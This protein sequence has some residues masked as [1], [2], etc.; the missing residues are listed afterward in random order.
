MD[1]IVQQSRVELFFVDWEKPRAKVFD[2]ESATSHDAPVSVWRTILVANEWNELQTLRRTS[3]ECTIIAL[4][5]LLVGC[6]LEYLA[7]PQ[8]S[9][10]NLS[11]GHVNTILRF[12]NT[13]F[14]WLVLSYGQLAY[15]VLIHERYIT[16]PKARQFIDL[17]TMAKVSVVILDERYHGYYLHC[18]SPYPFA[19]GS[20]VEIADQLK[21]E[22]AGLMSGRGLPGAPTDVQVFEMYITLNWRKN[23]DRMYAHLVS[24]QSTKHKLES[25]RLGSTSSRSSSRKAPPGKLVKASRKLNTFLKSFVE[26]HDDEF[27]WKYY[28]AQGWL[29]E[30]LQIP[31]EMGSKRTSYLIP[32]RLGVHTRASKRL[33]LMIY[34]HMS[35]YAIQ[36]CQSALPWNRT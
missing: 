12:F 26:N 5:F 25:G 36:F 9:S 1:K 18:R 19:D 32:G 10:T 15:R 33:E 16:E 34:S 27:R 8:P 14:W 6:K 2:S 24:K 23:Y 4:A 29:S 35:R 3:T 13:S 30:W 28:Q 7:T 22:E 11:V 31:P 17:C 20:M 21:Q